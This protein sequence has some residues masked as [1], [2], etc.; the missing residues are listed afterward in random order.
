MDVFAIGEPQLVDTARMRPGAV[1]EGD[2]ARV[3]RHRDVE[4][5]EAG[6]RVAGL[7]RLIGDR[8][9]VADRFQ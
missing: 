1:E 4:Q 3:L 7:L 6:L 9:D 8:Q 5:L 2:P